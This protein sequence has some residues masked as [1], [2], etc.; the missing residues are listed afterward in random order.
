MDIVRL[1]ST[2]LQISKICLGT[3]TYG[4]PKWR[5]WVLE[6]E[7]SRPFIKRALEA[8][9][10]FFD[11]ADVYSIGVSEEIVGRALKDFAD[12]RERI[13]LA[14][15]VNGAMGPSPNEAGLSRKHIL[16]AIDNS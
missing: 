4:S 8:G 6:E 7:A 12:S 1:G 14:T 3:M 11:T 2:G 15:K 9:I 16:H 13:V 5:D 10:N